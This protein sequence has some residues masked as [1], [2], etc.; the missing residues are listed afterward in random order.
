MSYLLDGIEGAPYLL[1]GNEAIARG[2][3]EAGISVATGYPGTPSSEII[4]SLSAIS[5]EKNIYVEWSVNEKVALEVAAAASFAGLRAL[6]AMKQNGVY[7][8]SD[9]LLHLA[10]SGTRGGMVLVT[11]DDPGALSSANEGESRFFA[12]LLEIPLL[13]PA[14]FQQAKDMI[15]W[16]FDLSEQLKSIVMVRS[17]TRLSHG[18]GNVVFG[19]LPKITPRTQF[20]HD[21]QLLD[22]DEGP[23]T[24]FPVI[25]KHTQQQEK[26]Q[27]AKKIFED[28]LFNNYTGPDAPELLI[29]TSSVCTLYAWEAL[30]QLALESKVGILSLGTT[31]PLPSGLLFQYLSGTDTVLILEEVLPFLEEQVKALAADMAPEIGVKTFY[32]KADGTIPMVGELNPDIVIDALATIG[33]ISHEAVPKDH[34]TPVGTVLEP[35]DRD[36]TFCPGCPHRASFW[37]IHTVLTKE[38]CKGFVCGDIGCYTMDLFCGFHTLKTVH[39]MGSGLGIA[40][41]FGNLHRF[42]M[43][44]A[45]IAVCGDST[46]FHAA[47]PALINA[48]HHKARI[49]LVVLDNKGTA[50][51][52][53]QPHPGLPTDAA[54]DTVPAV[55]IAKVCKAI[56]A[57]VEVKNPFNLK[58]TQKTLTKMIHTEGTNV[59]ILSQA[60][61]LSPQKKA[62]K[63]KVV[64]N[65]KKCVGDTCRRCQMYNCPALIWSD[66][67]KVVHIDEMFCARCGVC[68]MI[69]P[70]GAITRG[71]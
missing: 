21:G 58:E 42:G 15:V 59:L 1:M 7:V 13:E 11:C 33:I 4:E 29:I 43:D 52:G 46:F 68:V 44:Q 25:L 16:A 60:C 51:T 34:P 32:G 57:H 37:S 8:A 66:E 26:I 47:I 49:V 63:A 55:D 64:V 50:M 65:P 18:S 2:A 61:A 53:F 5:K 69:C 14:D 6:S 24:S 54:G 12:R 22:P 67:K 27:K 40:S 71:E 17:V 35:P 36:V 19:P 39:A 41:G 56:G 48:V 23:V 38:N 62:K 20:V 3:L 10:E 31:W 70:K 9:F 30:H 45:V 28:C